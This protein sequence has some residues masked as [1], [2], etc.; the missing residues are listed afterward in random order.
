MKMLI[1]SFEKSRCWNSPVSIVVTADK[2]QLSDSAGL[3]RRTVRHEFPEQ[4]EV[5]AHTPLV[6]SSWA[7]WKC[8]FYKLLM[9]P[10]YLVWDLIKC[11]S[12]HVCST[13]ICMVSTDHSQESFSCL[14]W[15]FMDENWAE[16]Y[17][18]KNLWL[19]WKAGK[20]CSDKPS[21]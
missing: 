11:K 21:P 12:F 17:Q 18:Q 1:Y 3:W 2:S 10:W 8:V 19:K 14:C 20:S 9:S 16:V 5:S 7:W 13:P 4:S 6:S 15:Y